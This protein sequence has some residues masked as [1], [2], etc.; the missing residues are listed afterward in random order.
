MSF[1]DCIAYDF[2]RP[3]VKRFTQCYRAAC[4]S[5]L[6][7]PSVKLVYCGQTVGCINVPLAMEVGLGAGHIVLGWDAAPSHKRGTAA[8]NF[9]PMYVLAKRLGGSRCHLLRRYASAQATLCYMGTQLPQRVAVPNVRPHGWMDQYV[10]WYESVGHV[11][12]DIVL[13]ADSAPQR[14]ATQHPHFSSHVYCGQTVV[15]LSNC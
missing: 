15:H 13:D 4:L 3:F 7:V 8:P 11:P 9:R 10:T 14:K 5:C 2:G 1:Y 12:G 6:S